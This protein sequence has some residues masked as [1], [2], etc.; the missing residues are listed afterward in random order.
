MISVCHDWSPAETFRSGSRH[1]EPNLSCVLY[2]T[3]PKLCGHLTVIWASW[4]NL[5]VA[6]SIQAIASSTLLGKAFLKILDGSLWESVAIDSKEHLEYQALMLAISVPVHPRGVQW[7][8]GQG[9]LEFLPVG[10]SAVKWIL[11]WGSRWRHKATS[12]ICVWSWTTL[13]VSDLIG[14]CSHRSEKN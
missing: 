13:C 14:T 7:G 3:W 12:P 9:S 10:T 1:A 4:T 5:N 11:I 6:P 2:T 8:W